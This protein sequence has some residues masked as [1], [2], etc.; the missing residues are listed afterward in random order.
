[1][2]FPMRFIR[3]SGVHGAKLFFQDLGFYF[4]LRL[5]KTA[6]QGYLLFF[7]DHVSRKG[8][9]SAKAN[10]DSDPQKAGKGTWEIKSADSKSSPWELRSEH[11]F[12]NDGDDV[13]GDKD[14]AKQLQKGHLSS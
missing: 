11:E 13:I 12:E 10:K 5:Y 6:I 14:A 9:P 2:Q 8:K 7:W 3:G 1:M 4:N